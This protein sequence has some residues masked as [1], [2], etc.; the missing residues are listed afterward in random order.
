MECS[1]SI[2]CLLVSI[3]FLPLCLASLAH[4]QTLDQLA[5]FSGCC[6]HEQRPLGF[7]L[8]NNPG[9]FSNEEY[10]GKDLEPDVMFKSSSELAISAQSQLSET[11]AA[12]LLPAV[13]ADLRISGADLEPSFNATV[14]SYSAAMGEYVSFVKITPV[15]PPGHVVQGY[16]I[17]LNTL[18]LMDGE[19]SPVPLTLGGRFGESV[20]FFIVVSVAGRLSST[21]ALSVILH[22]EKSSTLWRVVK[23]PLIVLGAILGLAA[24]LFCLYIIYACIKGS[25]ALGE[26]GHTL[27]W[28]PF[29]YFAQG[30]QS[31]LAAPDPSRLLAG[32]TTAQ[33]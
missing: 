6:G 12:T 24:I 2:L 26:S 20:E 14:F 31:G 23:W 9:S 21:Y 33:P 29:G 22:G 25:K 32:P 16:E 11:P 15:L 13:L 1:V 5:Q 8:N 27:G 3:I 18:A 7:N 4:Q 17:K 19:E 28:W 10:G 30:Q